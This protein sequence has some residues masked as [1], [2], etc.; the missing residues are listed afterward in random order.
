MQKKVIV[1]L[2]PT[3]L[4]YWAEKL[5]EILSEKGW[6]LTKYNDAVFTFERTLQ[7]KRH[8][9]I[10]HSGGNRKGDG[11]FSLTLRHWNI[12]GAYGL[13]KSKLNMYS[14]ETI[15]YHTIIEVDT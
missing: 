7:Q 14:R 9:F 1:F 4:Y 3:F 5:F 11:K 2:I 8:Y 12:L 15:C 13:K 6:M 10:Y